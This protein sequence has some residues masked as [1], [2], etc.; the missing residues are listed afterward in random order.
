MSSA[1]V[2]EALTAQMNS[3]SPRIRQ[4]IANQALFTPVIVGALSRLQ[5]DLKAGHHEQV[6]E[7]IAELDDLL[8]LRFEPDFSELRHVWLFAGKN[9]RFDLA[10]LRRKVVEAFKDDPVTAAA[11]TYGLDRL[12]ANLS[13]FDGWLARALDARLQAESPLERLQADREAIE[14]I[15]GYLDFL[16]TDSLVSAIEN[17]PFAPANIQ[18]PLTV[19]LTALAERLA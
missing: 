10:R 2:A 14:I 9:V 16:G 4:A 11:V 3:L 5:Q 17:N 6:R 1:W 18:A 19:T 15:E 8:K 7:G 13:T 12:T